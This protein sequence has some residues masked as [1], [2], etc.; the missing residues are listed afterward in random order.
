[1]EKM[2]VFGHFAEGKTKPILTTE[3]RIQKT[4][5]RRKR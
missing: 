5:N 4:E 3:V 1:M 2:V